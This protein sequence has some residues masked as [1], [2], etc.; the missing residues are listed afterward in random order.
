MF[1][2]YLRTCLFSSPSL[3]RYSRS[4]G[5]DHEVCTVA[6]ARVWVPQPA[7][8]S[9]HPGS[10]PRSP[11]P[12]LLSCL[13]VDTFT[14]ISPICWC[15]IY[16]MSLLTSLVMWRTTFFRFSTRSVFV[17]YSVRFPHRLVHFLGLSVVGKHQVVAGLT[18]LNPTSF[19]QSSD[20]YCD[21]RLRKS[22]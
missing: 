13:Q 19:N 20:K 18:H 10:R 4:V 14:P 2:S 6:S 22:E 5:S 8:L 21:F 7:A 9:M 1:Q 16:I 3:S 17:Y 15:C 11:G 12:G